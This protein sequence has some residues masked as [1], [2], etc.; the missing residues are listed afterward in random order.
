VNV[1]GG[2]KATLTATVT[3]SN[4][5]NN[6][7]NWS[8]LGTGCGSITASTAGDGVM[9]ATYT[10]ATQGYYPR[11]DCSIRATTADGGWAAGASVT[12]TAPPASPSPAPLGV[13]SIAGT[14]E[15][16]AYANE[17]TRKVT[18]PSTSGPALIVVAVATSDPTGKGSAVS[19][20]S[21]STLG[22]FTSIP[23]ATCA[24]NTQREVRWFYK[25]AGSGLSNEVIT[26]TWGSSFWG[27]RQVTA[28]AITGANVSPIG[29]AATNKT[30][31]Y[32]VTLTP[33]AVGS[34]LLMAAVEN[35]N[36]TSSPAANATSTLLYD[37]H[38]DVWNATD[39]FR[40]PG[41]TSNTSSVSIGSTQTRAAWCGGAV[42]IRAAR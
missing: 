28:F 29:A 8:V 23:G 36:N 35:G 10:S 33:Q 24:Y 27:I 26:P 38:L 39:V 17:S 2:Q 9:T 11:T 3:P 7:V 40:M 18:I 34:L 22:A 5:T 42:E 21:G 37:Y 12:I 20:V 32:A 30:G 25:A 41:T 19:G 14:W 1:Q 4:A 6:T 13:A 15:S 16:H 31:A